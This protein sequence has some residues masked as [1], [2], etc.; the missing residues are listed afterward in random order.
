[1]R[2]FRCDKCDHVIDFAAQQCP[3]C[4]STLGYV[5]ELQTITVLTPATE[6]ATYATRCSD[7]LVWRCLNSAWECNWTLA[8]HSPVPWCRACGLTRGRPDEDR[9]D[10][11][12]AWTL[13]EASKRRLIHQLD[14][15]GLPVEPRSTA[16]PDG[17][18]FD[19]VSLPGAGGI[20]GHLDGLITLD[21]A[22]IDDRFRD[23]LRRR[24][25]EPFRS[26]IGHLRHEIGHYYWARFVRGDSETAGFRRVFG[27]ERVDYAGAMQEHYTGRNGD[28]DP[29]RFIT[30]YGASHPLED[31]AETFAHYLH[32]LDATSTAVA[33]RLITRSGSIESIRGRTTTIDFAAVIDAWRPMNTAVNA[34]AAAVG[35][36]AV[37]PIDPSDC[38]VAK[39]TYVHE[40][41]VAHSSPRTG[42]ST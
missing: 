27:D 25:G 34:I 11:L 19:F 38:V 17:L 36:P 3:A 14:V 41:A 5:H 12:Y 21:L 39:L 2:I 35:A 42:R 29:R 8:A 23:D 24:L 31:W 40:R 32:I 37:F 28:W 26:V 33:H 13:A 16:A 18:A 22:E 20:T 1:M 4:G 6:P 15:L 7:E 10:A 9:S 30:A